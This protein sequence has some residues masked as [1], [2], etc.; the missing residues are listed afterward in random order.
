[1]FIKLQH[2]CLFLII[3]FIELYKFICEHTNT[4]CM[5]MNPFLGVDKNLREISLY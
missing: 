5:L 4:T 2:V 1:M 3:F